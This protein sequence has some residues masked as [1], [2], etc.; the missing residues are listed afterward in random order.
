MRRMV[1][2]LAPD[3]D[4]LDNALQRTSSQ[5][6]DF[7]AQIGEL[8]F[9]WSN[10]ESMFIYVLMLLLRTDEVAAAIVFSTLNTTRSRLDLA[11]RLAKTHVTD[12]ALRAEIEQ[13]IERFSR[14]TRIRNEFNHTTFSIDAGG[15]ITHT[16]S[17][18]LE[19][20]RGKLRFGVRKPVDDARRAEL[21]AAITTLKGINKSF[22]DIMQRLKAHMLASEKS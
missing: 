8:N 3:F 19:E 21:A 10:N 18:K 2:P 11:Q 15:T 17:M 5:R 16:Q 20:S 9:T 4:A 7:L 14:V 6:Q 13:L 1:L 22:W 12:N